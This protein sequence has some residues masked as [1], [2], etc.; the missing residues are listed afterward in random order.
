VDK[1]DVTQT[2]TRGILHTSVEF[3]RSKYD[4]IQVD[5]TSVALMENGGHRTLSTNWTDSLDMSITAEELKA[6]V[7]NRASKK[8]PESDGIFLEFFKTTWDI[9][10]V[11]CWPSSIRCTWKVGSWNQRNKV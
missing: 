7:F 9:Y 11:T 8:A 3:L 4:S 1:D 6:A 5:D 2:T 10:R